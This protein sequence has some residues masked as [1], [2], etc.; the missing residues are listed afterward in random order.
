MESIRVPL[1]S[2]GGGRGYAGAAYQGERGEHVWMDGVRIRDPKTQACWDVVPEE[3]DG[4]FRLVWFAES[5]MDDGGL[6]VPVS[7]DFLAALAGR[8]L[9]NAPQG[10]KGFGNAPGRTFRADARRPPDDLL[11]KDI[12]SAYTANQHP[13]AFLASLYEVSPYTVDDWLKYARAIPGADLPAPRRT[14][15]PRI[16]TKEG[17]S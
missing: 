17:P 12:R 9:A 11:L 16:N 2:S 15:R 13:R 5:S 3:R 8:W 6:G 1:R 10:M 14:G 7:R 4:R